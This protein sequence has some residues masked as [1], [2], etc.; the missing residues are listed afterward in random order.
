MSYIDITNTFIDSCSKIKSANVSDTDKL[1][2]YGLYKQALVGN[3]NIPQPAILQI[4]E[5]HKYNA[6]KKYHNLD[7]Y[8]AMQMYSDL[9]NKYKK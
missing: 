8:K 6:W 4:V 3:C 9:V 5:T 2:L 1:I 7:K